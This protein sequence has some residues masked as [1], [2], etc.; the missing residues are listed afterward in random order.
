[1]APP[2]PHR[3]TAAPGWTYAVAAGLLLLAGTGAAQP[4]TTQAL[5]DARRA[6]EES[7]AASAAAS[8]IADLAAATER[9]LA[10]QRV[11]A[12]RRVQAA[13]A[14]RAEAERLARAAHDAIA[15][16]A[17]EREQRSAELLPLLPVMRRLAV[18]PAE[19]MLAVPVPPETAL[20]GLLVLQGV[21]RQIAADARALATATAEERRRSMV[22]ADRAAALAAAETAARNAELLLEQALRE[23]RVRRLEAADA[24]SQA[25]RRAA[26]SAATAASLEAA[27]ERLRR[28]DT[29]QQRRQRE[30]D[31]SRAARERAGPKREDR[32]DPLPPPASPAAHGRVQPVAGRLVQD[33]GADGEAGPARGMTWEA[34]ARA[35]VVSPCA[36]RVAFAG[37]FRSFGQ[38]VILDCGGERHFV[39]AGLGRLDVDPGQRV[40]PGEPV[41]R[42]PDREG[43]SRLYGELR[44]RGRPIDPGPWLAGRGG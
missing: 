19:T 42:L 22:A 1:M 2:T 39:L 26:E 7:A 4:P 32:P 29:R 16:A 5:G 31:A 37:P 33:F 23:A 30:E 43:A 9:R 17:S 25:A 24:N 8:R 10:E 6:A 13:E 12:A 21:S 35:R 27:L 40:V 28:E 41:G 34:S 14:Q 38:L 44:A 36:G 20:R 11:E 15:L 18:H 3:R